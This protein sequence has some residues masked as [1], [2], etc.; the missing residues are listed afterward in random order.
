MTVQ[1]ILEL[2]VKPEEIEN[3]RKW[4]STNLPD[5]RGKKGCVSLVMVQ[6]QDDPSNLM[7]LEQWDTKEDYENYLGWRGERGDMEVLG[8]MVASE[9]SI[10]FYDSFGV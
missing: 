10:R 6:N 4:F 9:P 5:T 8:G 1:V 3:C 2:N 7:V